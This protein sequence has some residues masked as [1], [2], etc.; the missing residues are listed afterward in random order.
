MNTYFSTF[1]SG[2]SEII[3]DLLKN[4]L[5][6]FNIKLLLDGLVV[7]ETDLSFSQIRNLRFFN[8]NFVLEKENKNIKPSDFV[9]QIVVDVNIQ[10][11]LRDNIPKQLRTF[12]IV[13]S[14]QNQITSLDKSL[15]Q[16]LEEFVNL[17]TRLKVDK[18]K[19][20]I[21][22]WILERSEGYIFFGVRITKKQDTKLIL[23]QGELRS[24]LTNIL[25][26]L[27]EPKE[28]DV[29]LDPF[30]GSGAIPIER[31][32]IGKYKKVFAGESNKVIYQ[33][34]A[35]KVKSLGLN[36]IVGKWNATKLGALANESVDKIV[37]DPPWGEFDKNI[38]IENLYEEIFDEAYRI[39]KKSGI[40]IVLSSQKGLIEQILIKLKGKLK[41]EC[42][43]DILVSG[44]KAGI[45]KCIK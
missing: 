44:K 45:Y 17:N 15:T 41:L 31:I 32:A 18:V 11:S 4:K 30:A 34:L 36:I 13:Y 6:M 20:D 12:R 29:F 40:L 19:P 26:Q 42:K 33:K 24:E 9:K 5:D 39:L 43:F 38:N 37:T 16:R 27:S 14:K 10:K 23:E 28:A 22:L 25:C 7:F 3:R 2:T 21:E 35:Q 8:N 1:I